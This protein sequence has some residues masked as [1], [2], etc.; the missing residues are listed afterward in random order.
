MERSFRIWL[1]VGWT[2]AVLSV[3]SILGVVLMALEGLDWRAY[4]LFA[5]IPI[6]VLFICIIAIPMLYH[7][8]NK[9]AKGSKEL[10]EGK[11]LA[12]W[13]YDPVEWNLFAEGEW[14]RTKK[15][16]L[17]MPFGII[18]GVVVLGYLFKGWGIEDF[19]LLLPW[20]LGLAVG[21]ALLLYVY[22]LRVYKKR[23]ES[24]GEVFIGDRAV[25]FNGTYYT[26]DFL[27]G[28]LGT[29]ELLEGDP[30][31]LQFEIRQIGRYG[32]RSSEVRVPVPRK[33]EE[34]A[35]KLVAKFSA[36]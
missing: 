16:A 21:A 36:A 13:H 6:L 23:L 24:V 30:P 19:K 10:T 27:G 15:K 12:H 3:L 11:S 9:Y 18:A 28:S 2:V 32:N 22:G 26:W 29:V 14:S 34:E 5:L 25:L 31:I 33:H 7:Y 4:L 20:I 35:K 1:Q 8:R 17:W